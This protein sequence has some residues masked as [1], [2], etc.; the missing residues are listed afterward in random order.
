MSGPL[1]P[2]SV[3]AQKQLKYS[4]GIA[5]ASVRESAAFIDQARKVE[6]RIPFFLH[7]PFSN[8]WLNKPSP[9]AADG[10]NRAFGYEKNG[11]SRACW[12]IV[13]MEKESSPMAF[14]IQM[15][16]AK[17]VETIRMDQAQ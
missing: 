11:S 13:E 16:V 8:I 6:L 5:N 12:K 3:P 15:E 17:T 7:T 1:S 14:T 4:A 9:F 10:A 2:I